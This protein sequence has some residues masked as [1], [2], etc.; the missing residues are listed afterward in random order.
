M[1]LPRLQRDCVL[2]NSEDMDTPEFV[3]FAKATIDYVADYT[4]SLRDRNVLSDVEPGYLSKLLP[5][6]A[7]QTSEKWQEVL[8]DV[9]QH[10]MPGVTF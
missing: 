10:I 1:S 2:L 3:E 5:K 4:E 8:K 6:E 7:P 9:E